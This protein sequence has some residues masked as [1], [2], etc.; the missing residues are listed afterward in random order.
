MNGMSGND[1]AFASRGITINCVAPGLTAAGMTLGVPKD[2]QEA[3]VARPLPCPDRGS[4][5][6]QAHPGMGFTK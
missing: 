6:G 4:A 1:G 3:G 2:F 5:A